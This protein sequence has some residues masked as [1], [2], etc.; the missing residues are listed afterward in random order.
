MDKGQG[1]QNW[2]YAEHPLEAMNT[3][4]TAATSSITTSDSKN[5]IS[6]LFSGTVHAGTIN[7]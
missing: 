7:V 6:T 2:N 5:D 4:A 3:T 1:G